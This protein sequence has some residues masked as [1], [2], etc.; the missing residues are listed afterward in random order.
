MKK[1]FAF[2]IGCFVLP[3]VSQADDLKQSKF[4]QVVNR[5]Q[6]VSAADQSERA[7][8][9]SE[10]FKMPDLI[11]TGPDSRAEMVAEDK[12][13]TRIGANTVFSF[14][15][16]ARTIGLQQGSLLFHAPHGKGGGTIHTASATASVLGTT[17]IVSCTGNGGFKVLDLEGTVKVQ[18]PGGDVKTLNPGEMI[19]ILPGGGTSPILIFNLGDQVD[20][21]KLVNGFDTPLPSMDLI[22]AEIA[23][24][25]EKILKHQYDDAG[26]IITD[27]IIVTSDILVHEEVGFIKNGGDIIV[28]GPG[29]FKKGQ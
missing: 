21:S 4:T 16:A 23:R 12:T 10:I 28:I 27:G 22:N 18:L 25:L 14:D 6:V 11:R 20:G 8:A 1:L 15:P 2:T 13:I 3:L 17:I 26:V 24:Q 5:V 9:V 29:G 19:F 7:A